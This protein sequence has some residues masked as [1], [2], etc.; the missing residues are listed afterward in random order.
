MNTEIKNIL[1]PIDLSDTSLNALNTAIQMAKRHDAVLHLLY[2]QDLMHYYPEMGQLV[3]IAPMIED[4]WEKDRVLLDKI[5][6]AIRSSHQVNCRL[7]IE[8]GHRAILIA[9]VSNYLNADITVMGTDPE[10][11]K[12]SY[13]IDSLPYKVLQ[14]S[15]GHLLT[16]PAAK[17]VDQFSD[18]IFPVLGGEDAVNKLRLSRSIIKKN[19]ADVSVIGM[20]KKQ[21]L[22]LLNPIR[23]LA[24]RI[25]WRLQAI[26]GSVSRSSVYSLNVVKEL[27]GIAREKNAG[28]L[29]IEAKTRRD[30]KEF[31]FGS[32]TQRMIRNTEV[33]VLFVKDQPIKAKVESPLK[34]VH[35]SKL[36]L[37]Y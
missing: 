30:L 20:V 12:D 25:K 27:I 23:E 24:A 5:V 2:V 32:F 4:V 15:T 36:Q 34:L 26:A 9:E 1:I 17:A 35:S 7:H 29:V 11:A 3:T 19:H 18:I 37:N 16:V 6:M 14:N 28:L 33:A 22:G 10:L 8:T 21:D 13:L 31:F